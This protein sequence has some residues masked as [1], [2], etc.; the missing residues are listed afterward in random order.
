ML[1]HQKKYSTI[2][3]CVFV[4]IIPI[5]FGLFSDLLLIKNYDFI[6][7]AIIIISGILLYTLGRVSEKFLFNHEILKILKDHDLIAALVNNNDKIIP[8]VMFPLTMIMEEFI[9][10]FYAIGILLYL[11]KLEPSQSILISSIIFSLYHLHFWFRFKSRIIGIYF[12][13]FSF[14]L[15][16]LCGYILINLGLL[17]CILTHTAL[18]YVLYYNISQKIKKIRK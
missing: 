5:F 2:I 16:L 10:R 12:L 14:L 13:V 17:F 6:Q 15:G 18:A 9:F 4:G 7:L 3:F 8:L 11:L 1:E